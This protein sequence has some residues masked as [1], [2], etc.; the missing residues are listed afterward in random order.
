MRKTQKRRLTQLLCCIGLVLLAF[1][2]DRFPFHVTEEE[3]LHTTLTQ[4]FSVEHLRRMVPLAI[5][6]LIAG[7]GIFLVIRIRMHMLLSDPV[8]RKTARMRCPHSGGHVTIPERSAFHTIRWSCMIAFSLLT[9]FGGILLGIKVRGFSLPVLACPT[10]MDQLFESSCYF[11]AHIPVLL[12]EYTPAGIAL[13]AVS[14]MGS[15]ALLGRIICGFLCPMGLIQDL[16]HLIRRKTRAEGVFMEEKAYTWLLPVKWVMVLLMIGLVFAGGEFCYFCPALAT[17]PVLA[18]MQV[19]LYLSAF[20][21]IF[22][23]IGSFFKRRIWCNIC[24]L[25]YL[26]GLFHHVS[27]F[28]LKKDTTACTECGACYEACPMGIK[29]IY[30][31]REKTDV[32]DINCIL[33]GECIRRCPE[34]NALA[35]TFAGKRFYTASREKVV[36]G[37]SLAIG[38][39]SG[40]KPCTYKMPENEIAEKYKKREKQ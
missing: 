5:I 17:S 8:K 34:D 26:I 1:F 24:P 7:A 25:G 20:M 23:L 28:R 39:A 33:C 38:T 32:T 2:A 3:E 13:F 10:N 29:I 35:M 16:M 11:L 27:P 22:V 37:Y 18:G 6:L 21:M 36:S 40:K 30:T 4:F 12:E 15:A 14:T 19:S 9:I 31:E